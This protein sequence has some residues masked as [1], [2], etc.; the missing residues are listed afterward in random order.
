MSHEFQWIA[1]STSADDKSGVASFKA[2]GK[3]Y[4][5]DLNSFDDAHLIDAMLKEAFKAAVKV[6]QKTFIST[7]QKAI[8]EASEP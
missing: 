2:N 8:D 4:N 3:T 5:F 1:N 7:I 6:G